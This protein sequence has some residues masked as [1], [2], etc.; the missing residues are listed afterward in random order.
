VL[1]IKPAAKL[2]P[3]MQKAQVPAAKTPEQL[4]LRRYNFVRW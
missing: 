3:N 2:G 1:G 4:K